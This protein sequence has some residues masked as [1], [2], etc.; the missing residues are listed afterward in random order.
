MS[1]NQNVV[2]EYMHNQFKNCQAVGG[3]LTLFSSKWGE[4][5]TDPFVID[6]VNGYN[7]EFI[8]QFFPPNQTKPPYSV[9][10]TDVEKVAIDNEIIKLRQKNVIEPSFDEIGQ[11]VSPIF[12]R[13]KK[14]GGFRLILD[15]SELNKNV[16]YHH[17][18]MDTLQS[19]L[20]LIT[21]NCFMA[22]ID[23]RDA[24]Y[25]VPI[26]KAHRKFLKFL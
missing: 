14:D 5:T 23:L 21:P 3:R 25:T 13:P 17:F 15:L 4:L 1:P 9:M 24:Y 20:Q 19:A 6:A 12:V 11:F 26:A 8:P 18:K 22:S 10:F 2:G 7:I 16:Q